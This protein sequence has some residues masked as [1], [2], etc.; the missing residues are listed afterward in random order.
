MSQSVICNGCQKPLKASDKLAGKRVKC[1]SCQ[2]VVSI[3]ALPD[4]ALT[5]GL[6]GAPKAPSNVPKQSPIKPAREP[7]F[8]ED[9]DWSEPLES[10]HGHNQRQNEDSSDAD[11]LPE[12]PARS[13]GRSKTRRAGSSEASPMM[14][15]HQQ[16][17]ELGKRDAGS[18]RKSRSQSDTNV[19][20]GESAP[21]ASGGW[22]DHLHWVLAL[23]MLPL[24][25]SIVLPKP[26]TPERLAKALQ[27]N[28]QLEK[29]LEGVSSLEELFA[30][31]PDHRFPGAHLERN[32]LFHWGYAVASA[33]AFLL[34]LLAMFPD[35]K[36][37]T[38]RLLWTGVITGTVGIVLLLGFQFVAEWTQHFNLRGRSIVILFFY[39]VKFIGF[40]YRCATDGSTGFVLSFMGFTCG[41][42]LCEELCKALPVAIYLGTVRRPDWRA[43]CLVGLASGIG[44]GVSEGIMYSADYY[45][46]IAPGLTYL[47]R[48]ASCVALH[49]VWASSVALLMYGNQDYVPFTSMGDF[50]WSDIVNFILFYLAIAMVLHGLYD[51]L[52][53]Q[54]L[55]LGALAIAA[56]SFVWWAWLMQQ[57]RA[58]E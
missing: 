56:A 37:G 9:F 38:Q 6:D 44:F 14:F 34:L 17:D 18:R 29:Q 40:S 11:G 49:A 26:S 45:N 28:P 20:A 50:E 54:N 2:T 24:V 19:R 8:D 53:K 23:A 27:E 7:D 55:A 51:T 22:R 13:A 43:T 31:L 1:P 36:V 30:V 41:V 35:S 57:Q 48:F 33:A 25:L 46:G 52:L 4:P 10:A 16:G 39:I 42:G 21:R 5:S 3:P 47:V 15:T 12:L 32:T 58:A